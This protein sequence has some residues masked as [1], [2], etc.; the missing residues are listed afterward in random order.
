V[1]IADL[2]RGLKLYLIACAL[3]AAVI[4]LIAVI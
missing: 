3:Q 4:A 1:D 2:T